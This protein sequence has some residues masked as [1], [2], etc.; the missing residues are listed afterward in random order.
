MLLYGHHPVDLRKHPNDHWFMNLYAPTFSYK[1]T[2]V[3]VLKCSVFDLSS[4]P[5]YTVFQLPQICY[6]RIRT[7][8]FDQRRA[9]P[10]HDLIS[11]L[12]GWLRSR[13]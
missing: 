3:M 13:L 11:F 9:A 10:P 2:G 4:I 1:V 6:L 8:L 12:K 7:I 5:L